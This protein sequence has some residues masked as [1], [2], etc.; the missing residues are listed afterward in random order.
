MKLN[1]N[2]ILLNMA[3]GIKIM[4]GN[5][6]GLDEIDRSISGFWRSFL[7]LILGLPFT[8][9]SKL[10]EYGSAAELLG[11]DQQLSVIR[12]MI[13][14]EVASLLAY[15]LSLVVLYAICKSSGVKERYSIAVISLNWSSLAIT[16]FSFPVL[17]LMRG[18]DNAS[19]TLTLFVLILMAAFSFAMFN[20]LRL[21]LRIQFPS[22][23]TYV[24]VLSVF[25]II[26]YFMLLD[27]AG[28]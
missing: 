11:T 21:T 8:L 9:S 20:I 3:A 5:R 10:S 22:A 15:L 28:L 6:Q 12:Q 27:I 2:Y 23:I 14:H 16:V 26:S 7:V 1:V 13:T 4:L 18:L 17:V 19:T 25:E 24:F